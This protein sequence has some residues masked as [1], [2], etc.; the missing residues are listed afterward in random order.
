[1]K[2]HGKMLVGNFKNAFKEEFGVGIKVHRG[3]STAHEADDDM[4]VA[5]NR[6]DGHDGDGDVDLHGNMTVATAEKEIADSLGFKVQI[7]DRSGGNADNSSRLGS[8]R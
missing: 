1:M 7:L 3:M 8:L 4:T 5:A 6:K 2:V